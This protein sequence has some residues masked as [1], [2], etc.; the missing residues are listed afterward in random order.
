MIDILSDDQEKIFDSQEMS[1][2]VG[3]NTQLKR[4]KKL[5]ELLVEEA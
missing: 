3:C 4:K 5:R 2:P 1:D